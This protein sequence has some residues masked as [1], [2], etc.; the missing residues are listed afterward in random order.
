VFQLYTALA[1]KQQFLKNEEV[2]LLLTDSTP[3]FKNLAT[4]PELLKIFNNVFFVSEGQKS[5]RFNRIVR[6]KYY[7]KLFE[8]FPKH[9]LNKITKQKWNC[10][11]D[12]YF[13]SFNTFTI[14]LQAHLSNKNKKLKTHLFEDG[15]STYLI[16][17]SYKWSISETTKRIFKIK[18]FE[19]RFCDVFL[20]EPNMVCVNYGFPLIKISNPIE[21]PG[22]IDAFDK[23]IKNENRE[24]SE[25]F[26]FFE[27]SFNNDGLITNDAELIDMLYEALE[28][29]DFILKH[30]PRNSIDRFKEIL[31]TIDFPMFWEH[32]FLKHNIENK[33]I[34]TVSSNTAFVP[35]IVAKRKPTIVLLYKLFNGTSPI[36]GSGNFEKYVEKYLKYTESK[37]YIPETIEDFK[38]IISNLRGNDNESSSISAN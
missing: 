21:I 23:I 24:V 36:L 13:S 30:H 16:K 31:P 10:Y 20:F 7:R 18:N 6:S 8:L 27:E 38:E 26:I 17:S 29:K 32:Y 4:N 25:K 22:F 5:N 35:Y 14:R 37:V 19:D 9:Y 15:I 1:I 12:I 33:V 3:M 28:K 34:V 11:T 2:D